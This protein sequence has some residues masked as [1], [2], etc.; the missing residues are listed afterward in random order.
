MSDS[1]IYCLEK[2]QDSEIEQ[3][4]E[5]LISLE[6]LALKKEI[7][8]IYKTC[9]SIEGL[10]ESIIEL[11][12]NDHNFINYDVIYFVLEGEE[13]NIVIDDYCYSLQEIAELFEGR[14]TGKVL[15]FSNT[16]SLNIP[17]E[18]ARYFLDVT[19]AKAISGYGEKIYDIPS[20]NLD[21]VYLSLFNEF[22]DILEIYDELNNNFNTLCELLEF[23]L[24]Y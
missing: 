16:K 4:T 7:A 18:E 14:M 2:V 10:E 3:K 22:D 12:K 11:T 20:T 9:D 21:L 24:Y 15:H 1:F 19:G 8:S 17:N 6:K 5:V 23:K 13:N